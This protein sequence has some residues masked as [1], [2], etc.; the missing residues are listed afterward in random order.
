MW[1]FNIITRS[2]MPQIYKS[3]ERASVKKGRRNCLELSV[4]CEV[5]CKHHRHLQKITKLPPLDQVVCPDVVSTNENLRC[6]FYIRRCIDD[7]K[8]A[9]VASCVVGII[10]IPLKLI[11]YGTTPVYANVL[12]LM[13]S[14]GAHIYPR[15]IKYIT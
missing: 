13:P 1:E 7:L 12:S 10:I 6:R 15:Y 4:I 3:K 5:Q 2:K 9:P 8:L 14:R 11:H